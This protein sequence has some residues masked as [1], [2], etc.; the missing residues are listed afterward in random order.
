MSDMP[1]FVRRAIEAQGKV[2]PEEVSERMAELEDDALVGAAYPEAEPQ[3]EALDL[4]PVEP[5]DVP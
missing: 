3:Q 2:A 5:A 4:G 1:E